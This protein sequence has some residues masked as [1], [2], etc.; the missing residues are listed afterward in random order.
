M[1]THTHAHTH[2]YTHTHAHTTH[3]HTHIHTHKYTHTHVHTHLHTHIQFITM[4]IVYIHTFLLNLSLA[5]P[6]CIEWLKQVKAI[7]ILLHG[8]TFL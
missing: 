6:D 8:I 5:S 2:T 1:H 7:T 3:A 4:A